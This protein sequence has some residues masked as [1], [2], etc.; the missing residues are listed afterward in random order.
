MKQ[1]MTKMMAWL[2]GAITCAFAVS[3]MAAQPLVDVAWI[4]E[5]SCD[6][7]VRV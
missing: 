4:K 7:N 3:A 6:P 1:K 2:G 5:H